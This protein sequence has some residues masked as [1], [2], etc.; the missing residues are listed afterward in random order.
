MGKGTG[1]HAEAD[2]R[3]GKKG[4][5]VTLK[6][7][8]QR[9]AEPAV[10]LTLAT[11]IPKGDRAQWLVE[12]ASQ[13]NV[14]RVIWLATERGVVKGERGNEKWKRWAVE[15]A[16]QCRRARVL[17]VGESMGLCA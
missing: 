15:A 1:G 13:L 2:G 11:A 3:W 12:Q 4:V 14:S 8:L 7:E 5:V 6:G 9:D 17:A 16:K 10:E